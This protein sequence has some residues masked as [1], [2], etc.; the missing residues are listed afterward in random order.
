[1]KRTQKSSL[2]VFICAAVICIIFGLTSCNME[3]GNKAE[4]TTAETTL[5]PASDHANIPLSSTGNSLIDDRIPVIASMDEEAKA[6]IVQ[7]EEAWQEEM[8]QAIHWCDL[9]NKKDGSRYYGLYQGGIVIFQAGDAF[10]V[11][12]KKIADTSFTYP[13]VFNLYYYRNNEIITLEQAYENGALTAKDISDILETHVAYTNYFS[14]IA[15]E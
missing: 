14:P 3:I 5:L 2:T 12:E 13:R 4:T 15:T 7:A 6:L 8:K 1:M 10:M 9:E 11:T